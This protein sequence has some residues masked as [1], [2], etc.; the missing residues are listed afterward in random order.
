MLRERALF[1]YD[2]RDDAPGRG[3]LSLEK[4]GAA[5]HT[6]V[7]ELRVHNPAAP[8][9]IPDSA[10]V[11]VAGAEVRKV[12]V[13]SRAVSTVACRPRGVMYSGPMLAL[14]RINML[15]GLPA[16]MAI[17]AVAA[18]LGA[19][20]GGTGGLELA[21]GNDDGQAAGAQTHTPGSI[22]FVEVVTCTFG[23][24]RVDQE[25]VS[26]YSESGITVLPTGGG[27]QA[28][29]EFGNPAPSVL[30]ISPAGASVTGQVAVTAGGSSFGFVSADLYASVTPIPYDFIGLL[31][32]TRVFSVTGT[33]PNTF[34]AFAT[35]ANPNAGDRIDTLVIELTN[36]SDCCENPMGLDNVV[37]TR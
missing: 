16:S 25:T 5:A 21:P 30:F 15:G 8:A 35:V 19:G 1:E 34:G 31:G 7:P 4:R 33:V 10:R 36:G 27:W 12:P 20:C 32:S 14:R 28:R 18:G 2:L 24:L 23:E 9:D 37:V 13:R 29:S 3:T 11:A 22:P 26:S 6:D 17:W